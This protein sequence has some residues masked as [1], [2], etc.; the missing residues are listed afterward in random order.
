[1]STTKIKFPLHDTHLKKSLGILR[2]ACI[3]SLIAP[4]CFYVFH[5]VPR[6]N[7]YKTFYSTYDP[8]DAFDRMQSGGYLASCPKDKKDSK[9]DKKK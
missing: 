5:N 6:K 3:L 8:I 4:I 2:T 9:N 7:K 1:M